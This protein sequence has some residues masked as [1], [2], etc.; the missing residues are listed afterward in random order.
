MEHLNPTTTLRWDWPE[1][2]CTWHTLDY[3]AGFDN[4]LS[5]PWLRASRHVFDGSRLP[6]QLAHLEELM[7]RLAGTTNQARPSSHR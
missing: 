2:L 3:H 4:G 1:A 6:S 7:G 5:M